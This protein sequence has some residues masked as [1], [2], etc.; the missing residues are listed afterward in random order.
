[1]YRPRP[2]LQL[3]IA[4]FT[5]SLHYK[6]RCILWIHPSSQQKASDCKC[7]VVSASRFSWPV[8]GQQSTGRQPTDGF[9]QG[10][11][12][13][14]H[15][16]ARGRPGDGLAARVDRGGDYRLRAC[17]TNLNETRTVRILEAGR[18]RPWSYVP[19]MAFGLAR[20][21]MSQAGVGQEDRSQPDCLRGIKIHV[22]E[23]AGLLPQEQ[24]DVAT[25]AEVR[26]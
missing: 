22:Y 6:A 1:L 4:C 9:P 21:P 2:I 25:V 26:W 19:P 23:V 20:S 16:I 12:I 15:R 11:R 18:S 14:L 24:S 13:D 10:G 5:G 8:P 3:G 7:K 17:G